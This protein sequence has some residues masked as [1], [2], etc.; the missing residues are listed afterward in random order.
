MTGHP[1]EEHVDREPTDEEYA[2]MEVPEAE[3]AARYQ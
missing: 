1:R 3:E 2:D